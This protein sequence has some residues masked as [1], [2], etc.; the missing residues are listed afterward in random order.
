MAFNSYCA[1]VHTLQNQIT[2]FLTSPRNKGITIKWWIRLMSLI[3]SFNNTAPTVQMV[4]YLDSSLIPFTRFLTQ[5]FPMM[6]F[7]KANSNGA[8]S[9]LSATIAC[10]ENCI[11]SSLLCLCSTD[12]NPTVLHNRWHSVSTCWSTSSVTTSKTSLSCVMKCRTWVISASFP[13]T[14][15]V[16]GTCILD[17]F[18]KACLKKAEVAV[19]FSGEPSEEGNS[20]AVVIPCWTQ[21][22]FT[23]CMPMVGIKLDTSI[24]ETWCS[25]IQWHC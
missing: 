2:I 24:G 15:S 13:S 4:G 10:H 17:S 3:L 22:M 5:T 25:D 18:V 14:D 6:A 11:T 19:V 7:R 1:H 16:D 12:W 20:I 21:N 8:C 23:A 9:F